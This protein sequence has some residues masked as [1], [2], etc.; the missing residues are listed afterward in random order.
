MRVALIVSDCAVQTVPRGMP[1]YPGT[2]LANTRRYRLITVAVLIQE[3]KP[4]FQ[5]L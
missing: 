2:P 3:C 5:D 4:W 1:S